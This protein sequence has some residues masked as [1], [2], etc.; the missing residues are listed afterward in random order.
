MKILIIPVLTYRKIFLMSSHVRSFF[1]HNP[2]FHQVIWSRDRGGAWVGKPTKLGFPLDRKITIVLYEIRGLWSPVRRS[3]WAP[4]KISPEIGG[5]F[6]YVQRRGPSKRISA[7]HVIDNAIRTGP[8]PSVRK[9]RGIRERLSPPADT[10]HGCRCVRRVL[11][12][13]HEDHPDGLHPLP[14][15]RMAYSLNKRRTS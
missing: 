4:A 12:A 3:F 8:L 11:G 10:L 2:I 6:R 13:A 15:Q 1:A 5:L 9:A 14:N 7:D